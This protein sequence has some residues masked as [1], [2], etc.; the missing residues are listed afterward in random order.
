MSEQHGV[1][2][3]GAGLSG[4]ATA[5]GLALRGTQVTVFEAGELLGGAAA[6]SGG[7]VWC[8]ANHVA[9]RE[10]IEGDTLDLAERY[11]RAIGHTHPELLDEQAFR[12]WLE[13]SPDAVRYWAGSARPGLDTAYSEDQMKVG[14]KLATKLLNVSKFVLAWDAPAADA[15]ATDPVDTSMLARLDRS[16]PARFA[17]AF[18]C[19]DPRSGARNSFG[20]MEASVAA[21]RRCCVA[22]RSALCDA[23]RRV[24]AVDLKALPVSG[25]LTVG[26]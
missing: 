20:V 15:L 18:I 6:Y 19:G 3:V 23:R 11:V 12:R 26:A 21:Y 25:V 4:L 1:I 9:V 7:Q 2:V 17:A 14:R 16:T 10:G 24:V 13:V 8:G 22:R 5:L